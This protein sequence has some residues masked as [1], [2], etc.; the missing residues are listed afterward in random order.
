MRRFRNPSAPALAVVLLA[1][2]AGC[3]LPDDRPRLSIEFGMIEEFATGAEVLVD[4]KVVGT[5][6]K[7]GA[8]T[9]TSFPLDMGE[10]EVTLRVPGWETETTKVVAELKG[11][12]IRLMPEVAESSGADGSMGRRISFRR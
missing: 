2:L 8:Q 10:H 6:D 12:K 4:G 7:T 1:A 5:L 11:Q 3:L 9:R